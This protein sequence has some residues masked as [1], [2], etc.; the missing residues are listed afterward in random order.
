MDS[1]IWTPFLGNAVL[2]CSVLNKEPPKDANMVHIINTEP[3]RKIVYWASLEG[4]ND[5]IVWDAYG[6]YSNS[7]V[8]TADEH[9]KA[10]LKLKVP[11]SYLL[12]NGSKLSPHIHYRECPGFDDK[13]GMMGELKTI[14]IN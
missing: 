3:G 11:S 9:G 6:D 2:P 8:V 5:K 10:N 4:Q 14:M 1:T 13:E 12:P 7:G